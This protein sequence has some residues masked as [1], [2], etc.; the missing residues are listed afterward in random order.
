MNND[1]QTKPTLGPF[2]MGHVFWNYFYIQNDGNCLYLTKDETIDFFF[3]TPSVLE[4][5]EVWLHTNSIHKQWEFIKLTKTKF[6]YFSEPFNFSICGLFHFK[7]VYKIKNENVY[8]W[9]HQSYTQLTVEPREC[10]NLSIYT[11]IPN[12]SGEIPAWLE[13][14]VKIKNLG[15]NAIH[16]LPITE[17]DSSQSPYAAKELFHIDPHY[18]V[19]DKKKTEKYYIDAMV[20]CC[21]KNCLKLC[22]DLVFNH[23]GVN[24]NICHKFPHWLQS[25]ASELNGLKRAGCWHNNQWLKWDDIVLIDFDH[26]EEK[27]KNE[28]W[29]YMISYALFWAEIAHRTNGIIRLDNLHA[30]NFLFVEKALAE[31]KKKFPNIIIQA[32]LFADD[33]A[34]KKYMSKCN[35][36]LL[37]ATPWIAPYA[38]DFRNQIKNI[39]HHYSA[40]RYI[41]AVNSHDS[42]S[43]VEMY[44]T[45]QAITPR[46]AATALM[47]TGCTGMVQGTEYGI[48]KKISF[49]SYQPRIKF[50][51]SPEIGAAITKINQLKN[52]YLT[53]QTGGNIEFIDNEN[54]AILACIRFGKKFNEPDFLIITNFNSTS[55]QPLSLNLTNYHTYQAK[56]SFT[57]E[58]IPLLALKEITL[59]PSQTLIFEILK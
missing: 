26:P 2:Q 45:K 1:L 11:Y 21:Q 50:K 51:D 19:T 40:K 31:I 8:F 23:V 54:S 52:A 53:F 22:L 56:N 32:E 41:F 13:D 16:L 20:E 39:H 36:N 6:N 58:I 12:A 28:I 7:I 10:H 27:V 44:G 17:L 9:D 47:S 49:K 34:I 33:Y 5:E 55:E 14:F 30:T 15:F 3:S 46:Y 57:N 29:D 48:E 25:D 24:S 42:D 35:I 18:F 4:I 43:A 59:Y 38:T 37:L